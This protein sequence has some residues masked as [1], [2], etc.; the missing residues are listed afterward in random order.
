MRSTEFA[1]DNNVE[2][3]VGGVQVTNMCAGMYMEVN[4]LGGAEGIGRSLVTSCLYCLYSQLRGMSLSMHHTLVS[5][6][7]AL[8]RSIRSLQ[9][10]PCC[11]MGRH[12]PDMSIN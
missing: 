11:S 5:T 6:A 4:E 7:L 12:Y 8:C 3:I 10:G 2:I 9:C 1:I